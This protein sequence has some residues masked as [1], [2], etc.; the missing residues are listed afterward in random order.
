MIQCKRVYDEASP[1]DGTRVLVDRLWPRGVSKEEAALN[2]W[3]KNIAPSDALRR[4]FDHDTEKWEAF[5][6]RYAQELNEKEALVREIR[7][8]AESGTITLVYAAKDRELNH[9]VVLK[10]YLQRDHD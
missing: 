4:W 8:K 6:V 9:A 1:E 5:Q 7:S 10:D 2:D 3:M